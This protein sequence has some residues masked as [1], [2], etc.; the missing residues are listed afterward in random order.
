MNIS[1]L[2]FP[3]IPVEYLP[4]F[5]KDDEIKSL[6]G[7]GD[8]ALYQGNLSVAENEKAAEYL[9][10]RGFQGNRNPFYHCRYESITDHWRNLSTRT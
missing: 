1:R 7:I 10:K 2:N 6:P 5:H 4:S 3:G 9:D 8:F